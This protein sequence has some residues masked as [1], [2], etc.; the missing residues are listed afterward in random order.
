MNRPDEIFDREFDD[1]GEEY[2]E[3]SPV[4]FI[5]RDQAE[6]IILDGDE[7]HEQDFEFFDESLND[8]DFSAFKGDFKSSLKQLN[9]KLKTKKPQ[10]KK[11][12][13][14]KP[15]SR[16]HGVE[17]SATIHGVGHRNTTQKIMVPRNRPI[18]IKTVDEFILADSH[19]AS[20]YKNIGYYHGKKLS[21]LILTFNNNSL[22]DFN[23]EL[24]NPSMMLDYLFT[25][26]G[27][28]NNKIQLG[29]GTGATYSDM[30]FYMLANPTLIPSARLIV[31]GPS[32][33][34]QQ[35]VSMTFKNKNIKGEQYVEPLSI[36]QSLDVMQ[37]Q[38]S[39]LSFDIMSKL[40]RPFIPDGMDV[41]NYTILA[42]NTVTMCFYY[43]QKK[44]K[45]LLFKEAR[46]KKTLM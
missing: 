33:A 26:G 6:D 5:D 35:S 46:D 15:L 45:K 13:R 18:K 39:T 43:K 14:R 42:G 25:T 41:I 4:E 17:G 24:F 30:L 1:D 8:I 29:S 28:L 27:N 37:V 23:L 21:E 2:T 10:V 9:G 36:P 11:V 34:A 38:S 19:E 31:A 22:I 12:A 32:V 44:L 40:N 7:S 16:S 3:Q 20:E